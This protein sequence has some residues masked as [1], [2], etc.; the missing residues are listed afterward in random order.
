MKQSLILCLVLLNPDS[1]EKKNTKLI[2]NSYY[3]GAMQELFSC[4]LICVRRQ[5]LLSLLPSIRKSQWIFK[6]FI[7]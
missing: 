4:G 7:F 2:N 1:F 6:T 3:S 5:Y